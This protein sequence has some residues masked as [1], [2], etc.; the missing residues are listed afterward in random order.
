MEEIL[1]KKKEQL[2]QLR[3]E[4][5]KIRQRMTIKQVRTK[6]SQVERFKVGIKKRFIG[7]ANIT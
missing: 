5:E 7:M 1:A 6:W 3:L 4:K 2:E